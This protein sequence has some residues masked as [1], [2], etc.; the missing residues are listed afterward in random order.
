MDLTRL[1]WLAASASKQ[2][3]EVTLNRA[4]TSVPQATQLAM[5]RIVQESLT[6]IVRHAHATKA[7]IELSESDGF[8]EVVI[9]D[10]GT[11]PIPSGETEG[12]GLLGMRELAELLGGTLET[13]PADG[14]GFRVAARIPMR[15]SQAQS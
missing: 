11:A 9:T 3:V 14:G 10:N 13:G 2:G 15:V 5:F 12:R 8:Y 7:H 4:P 1:D 6:N